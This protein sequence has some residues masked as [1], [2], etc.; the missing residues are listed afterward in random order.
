MPAALAQ[1]IEC[2]AEDAGRFRANAAA[3]AGELSWEIEATRL[4][5]LVDHVLA[6]APA[7]ATA[8]IRSGFS[9]HRS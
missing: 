6:G 8:A 5:Q 3:L 4:R 1:A 7:P 9:W 2:C